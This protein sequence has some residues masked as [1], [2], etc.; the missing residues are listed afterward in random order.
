MYK[1]KC[2]K[3][4]DPIKMNCGEGI[5]EA[6]TPPP[7]T[8]A[9]C[10]CDIPKKML[11]KM[12]KTGSSECLSANDNGKVSIKFYCDA[13]GNEYCD[14]GEKIKEITGKCKKLKKYPKK[15]LA[16]VCNK[17]KDKVCKCKKQIEFAVNRMTHSN[18]IKAFCDSDPNNKTPEWTLYCD[19][20]DN[21]IW[22]KGE[23]FEKQTN[24]CKKFAFNNLNCA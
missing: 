1:D 19:M 14:E 8:E 9:P 10:E 20:N 13:N 17:D 3:K 6:T 16:N 4:K 23:I 24:K 15:N 2:D 21:G 5:P 7:T 22:D 18:K 12:G 11:S